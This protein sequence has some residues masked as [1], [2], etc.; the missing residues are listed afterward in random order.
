MA[1]AKYCEDNQELNDE[2]FYYENP[3]RNK[4]LCSSNLNTKKLN[5]HTNFDSIFRT[6]NGIP[7]EYYRRLSE[8]RPYWD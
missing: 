1:I 8:K 3:F 2:R 5:D 4:D 6:S 7:E